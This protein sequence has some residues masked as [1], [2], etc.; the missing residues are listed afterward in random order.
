MVSQ[1]PSVWLA[2]MYVFLS[3]GVPVKGSRMG[4]IKH[5]SGL[6]GGKGRWRE[7]GVDPQYERG[8]GTRYGGQ[9]MLGGKAE[10]EL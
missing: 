4:L 8:G 7:R 1:V 5:R 6:A 10:R 9:L 3:E 2:C